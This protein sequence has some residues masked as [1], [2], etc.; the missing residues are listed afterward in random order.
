MADESAIW[1]HS[2]AQ[3]RSR[4]FDPEIAALAERQHGLV[5]RAQ[6]LA[7]GLGR[8]AIAYRIEH[9]R[10]HPIHPGVYAVGHRL[11][12]VDGRWMAAVLA[13]GPDAVVSHRD[14]G[15]IWSIRASARARVDIIV[16]RKLRSRDG[17]DFHYA[18]LP[19]DEVTRE[20]GIPVTTV[21]RTIFD[22]ASVVRPR[23]VERAIQEAEYRRLFDPL[24]LHDLHA[25]YP[26]A[27]GAKVIRAILADLD[28][29]ATITKNDL[30]EDFLAFVDRYRLPRPRMNHWLQIGDLWIEAD[31]VWLDQRVIVELDGRGAHGTRKAFE[32]DRAR[33]RA[34]TVAGWRV[35]RVTWRQLCD[36]QDALARDLRTLLACG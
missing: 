22:L 8:R 2:G 7:L 12:S 24:S 28:I 25:R 3:S 17:F 13:A 21:P 4:D 19:P 23:E 32:S 14:A 30:E 15:V 26:R 29:D 10:L 35:I 16:P 27:R 33:D 5:S 11:V 31:C 18:F 6:L 9:G 34:A 20:R 1:P 36:D